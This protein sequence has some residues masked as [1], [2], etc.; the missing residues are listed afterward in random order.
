MRGEGLRTGVPDGPNISYRLWSGH[1]VPTGNWAHVFL[2]K[3]TGATLSGVWSDVPSAT[4][5][6][7]GPLRLK[8]DVSGRTLTRTSQTGGFGDA[9]WTKS[10]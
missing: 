10:S 9:N 4:I 2:G 5:R 8:I 6:Q 1:S 7:N 3:I